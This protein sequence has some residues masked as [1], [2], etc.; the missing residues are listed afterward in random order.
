[1][2]LRFH[3]SPNG[4]LDYFWVHLVFFSSTV[5]S[6]IKLGTII[7]LFLNLFKKSSLLIQIRQIL[8]PLSTTIACKVNN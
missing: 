1:M 4:F 5:L 2:E 7:S 3:I 6:I 8:I